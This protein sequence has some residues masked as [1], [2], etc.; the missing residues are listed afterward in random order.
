VEARKLN[1]IC[2]FPASVLRYRQ[3][4]ASL[5][6][7]SF[8]PLILI[9]RF[10]LHTLQ[11]WLPCRYQAT[12]RQAHPQGKAQAHTTHNHPPTLKA[13]HPWLHF[14]RISCFLAFPPQKIIKSALL[15]R[16]ITTPSCFK[17]LLTRA[18]NASPKG[19]R[20]FACLIYTLTPR[21]FCCVYDQNP[22]TASHT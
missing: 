10:I 13:T 22:A 5:Y 16:R 11:V 14:M 9:R 21:Q 8:P 4:F 12:Q 7:F 20:H 19:P 6:S 15:R 1:K 3:R 18:G 2:I 17:D